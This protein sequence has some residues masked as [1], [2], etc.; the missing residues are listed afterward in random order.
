MYDTVGFEIKFQ[1]DFSPS[2]IMYQERAQKSMPLDKVASFEYS[3]DDEE[4]KN[5][6]NGPVAQL[7]RASDS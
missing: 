5:L 6:I 7:V 4:Y 3:G 2:L 1:D